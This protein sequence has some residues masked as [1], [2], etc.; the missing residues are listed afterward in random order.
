K[1]GDEAIGHGEVEQ[2]EKSRALP[3][4]EASLRKDVSGDAIPPERRSFVPEPGDLALLGGA[5]GAARVAYAF[6]FIVIRRVLGAGQIEERWS[7]RA[8][9]RATAQR[10]GRDLAPAWQGRRQ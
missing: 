5:H 7:S 10:E 8:E 6:H 2:C 9:L 1:S 3:R 4:I